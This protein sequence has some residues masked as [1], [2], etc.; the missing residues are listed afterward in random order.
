MHDITRPKLLSPKQ[1]ST[2]VLSLVMAAGLYLAGIVYV[3]YDEIQSALA[4]FGAT[5]WFILLACSC[6][7]YALRFVRWQSYIKQSGIIIPLKRHILYYLAGFALTTTP[8]KAGET[9]RSMLLRPH[10]VRYAFSLACFFTERLLDVI[11]VALLASFTVFAFSEHKMFVIL[12]SLIF[13]ALLPLIRSSLLLRALKSVRDSLHNKRL[14]HFLNHLIKLFHSAHR[15]LSWPWLLRGLS[16][17]F[18]AWLVQGFAFYLIVSKLGFDV[19]LLAALGIYSI[20]LLAG[21]LSFIPGG[22]GSTE[23]MMGILLAA[24]GADASIVVGAPIISRLSTLWFAV[25]LGLGSTGLLTL[26]RQKTD[27]ADCT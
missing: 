20:S 7:N 22:V 16:L 15:F 21:A 4:K 24:L 1:R 5:N 14:R 6:C 3:G 25:V 8:G 2:I 27:N 19:G 17:G 23:I 9:I 26:I 12:S 18:V 10:G 13:L 11:I